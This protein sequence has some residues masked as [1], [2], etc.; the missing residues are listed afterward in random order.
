MFCDFNVPI[1]AKFTASL[2]FQVSIA[3]V[4]AVLCTCRRV[5]NANASNASQRVNNIQR[6]GA[7][8]MRSSTNVV[9]MMDLPP[10][11]YEPGLSEPTPC[12]DGGFSSAHH[13]TGHHD[14]GCSSGLDSGSGFS[15]SGGGFSSFGGD[16]GGTG[17]GNV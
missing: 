17:T 9:N 15:S 12:Y 6:S 16:S 13:T 7:T 2:Y 11:P 8:A 1:R 10:P 3:A 4:T 14:G 5:A